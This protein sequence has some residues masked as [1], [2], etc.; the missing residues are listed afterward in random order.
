LSVTG[1]ANDRRTS[2]I[3][4]RL[5]QARAQPVSDLTTSVEDYLEV[6]YELMQEKGYARAVDISKYLCVRSPSVTSMLQRLHK[7]GLVVY[8]RY[9]GITL[10]KK[11]ERLA[12]S[13][14]ERHLVIT[15]FLR[16]L[17][18]GENIANSDAEGIEHHVH[19][20]TI[21]RV[22][23]FVDFV[24]KNKEWFAMFERTLNVENS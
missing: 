24:G 10:T 6:I 8:E 21:D 20:V 14:K 5:Q 3:L 7:K 4:S 11:G 1:L 18:V 15:Q 17:G 9:R 23:R 12:R 13:V 16:I 22:T 19:K 2:Y